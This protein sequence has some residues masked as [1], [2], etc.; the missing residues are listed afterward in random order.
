VAYATS[1][2]PGRLSR[3]AIREMVARRVDIVHLHGVFSPQNNELARHLRVPYVVSPHGGYAAEALAYHAVRKRVFASLF[4]RPMLHRAQVVCALT[5]AEAEELRRFGVTGP[6]AVLPNG[7]T[8]PPAASVDRDSLRTALGIQ[9]DTRVAIYA[10]RL[11]VRAKRLDDVVRAIGA[12]SDWNAHLIGGDFRNGVRHLEELVRA[13]GVQD[14]VRIMGPKRGQA[15]RDE[16]A[17]ADVFVLMS[18]SEGMPMALLEAATLGIPAVVSPEVERSTG[19]AA[20]GAAWLTHPDELGATLRRL[21][22]AERSEWAAR[23]S[24]AIRYARG[25][26]WPSIAAEYETVYAGTSLTR[27]ETARPANWKAGSSVPDT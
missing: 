8:T 21:A 22:R 1:R 24:E 7:V 12:T 2:I 20:Y 18:R 4:E 14:R 15:L 9:P 11:D 3:P 23:S 13:M 16:L 6:V 25:H 5:P 27:G 10:G 17:C 26:D 19:V